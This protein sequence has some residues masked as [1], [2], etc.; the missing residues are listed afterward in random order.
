M[1]IALPQAHYN[2][3]KT[4]TDKNINNLNT[5]RF[6]RG[7]NATV[8]FITK[9]L[10]RLKTVALSQW[11]GVRGVSVFFFFYC[12]VMASLEARGFVYSTAGDVM[13][14]VADVGH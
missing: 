11:F 8:D 9:K 10:L 7:D 13:T 2:L 5:T 1:F 14:G 6:S 12:T 3:L 4:S